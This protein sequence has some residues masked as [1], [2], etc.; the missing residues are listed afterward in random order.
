MF[1]L[2]VLIF[3]LSVARAES[4]TNQC[5]V[6]LGTLQSECPTSF[7]GGLFPGKDCCLAVSEYNKAGCFCNPV[8]RSIL[9]ENYDDIKGLLKGVCKTNSLRLSWLWWAH[10]NDVNFDKVECAP[11]KTYTY[12]DQD[13]NQ[14]AASDWNI[15]GGRFESMSAFG[16][17]LRNFYRSRGETCFDDQ[18]FENVIAQYFDPTPSVK[19]GYGIG[20]YNSIRSSV[21]YLAIADF[22]INRGLWGFGEVDVLA[23]SN[24]NLFFTANSVVLGA[25]LQDNW[26]FS[27]A[28]PNGVPCQQ[29]PPN[30]YLEQIGLFEG[31]ATEIK[32]FTV[33]GTSVLTGQITGL[34]DLGKVFADVAGQASTWGVKGIC[35]YHERYCAGGPFEQFHSTAEC[36]RFLTALPV[37]SPACGTGGILAGNST[38]CRFKHHFM[39]PLDP[40]LHC[41]HIGYGDHPDSDGVFKCNDSY[42]CDASKY[43][44]NTVLSDPAGIDLSTPAPT[45]SCT[46]QDGQT[47]NGARDPHL[48]VHGN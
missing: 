34:A 3:G 25:S 27:E 7:L 38:T 20:E 15:D 24:A 44:P 31:C 41:F 28:S 11:L 12:R 10:K 40:S 2:L 33:P 32:N 43:P 22:R 8:H 39:I 26:A 5:L 16:E 36:E 1:W 6:L 17:V 23:D 35:E 14:C 30:K 13:G 18:V 9:G 37:V 46:A 19:V 48:C 42:E 45:A 21:E 29:D 47:F 4:N